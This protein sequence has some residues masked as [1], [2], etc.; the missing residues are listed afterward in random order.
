M[1]F[2]PSS[3]YSLPAPVKVPLGEPVVIAARTLHVARDRFG[4]ELGYIVE[5]GIAT[6]PSGVSNA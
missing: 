3:K 2:I 6:Q 1:T 5:D 4:R